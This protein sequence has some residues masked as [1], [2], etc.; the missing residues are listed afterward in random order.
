[1]SCQ[2]V[3]RGSTVGRAPLLEAGQVPGCPVGSSPHH[4]SPAELFEW[5]RGSH[6]QQ[7]RLE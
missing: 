5:W 4:L 3:G 6:V 1:M 7:G 2:E